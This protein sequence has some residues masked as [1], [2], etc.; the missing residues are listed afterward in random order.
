MAKPEK[1]KKVTV[2]VSQEPK[3]KYEGLALRE[4]MTLEQWVVW[5]LEDRP[6]RGVVD[7]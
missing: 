7:E 3:E 6:S 5:C 1:D 2:R 4:G